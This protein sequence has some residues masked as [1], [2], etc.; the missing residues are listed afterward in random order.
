MLVEM[1]V[2]YTPENMDFLTKDEKFGGVTYTPVQLV[3]W[4]V[5]YM[6][7][8]SLPLNTLHSLLVHVYTNKKNETNTGMCS[9]R[10]LFIHHPSEVSLCSPTSNECEALGASEGR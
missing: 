10:K 2:T 7:S 1:D 4:Q 3:L 9:N 8:P 6:H 5:W